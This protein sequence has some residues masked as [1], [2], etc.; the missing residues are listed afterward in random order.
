M[1]KASTFTRRS[2]TVIVVAASLL[3]GFGAIQASAAWT[4]TAAPLPA[5]PVSPETLQARLADES[6]RSSDLLGRLQALTGHTD[7]LS[8]ALQAAQARIAADDAHAA[9]LAKDL[10]AAKR[11]LAK[12]ERSIKQASQARVVHQVVTTRPAPTATHHD[13]DGGGEHDDD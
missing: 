2:L 5:A 8:S 6:A 11:R 1:S 13:D 7:E 3:L 12:L 10:A 4:T 9:Q